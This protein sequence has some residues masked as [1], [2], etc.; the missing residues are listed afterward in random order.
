M[1]KLT[2]KKRYRFRHKRKGTFEGIYLKTEKLDADDP[3]DKEVLIVAID[4]ADG[5]GAEWLR[6]VKG[7][8]ST[9]SG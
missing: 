1:Q 8:M 9:T 7:A 6:R 3:Q 5:T 2:R 4:T